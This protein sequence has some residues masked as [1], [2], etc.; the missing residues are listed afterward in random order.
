MCQRL[1][2]E[3]LIPDL[4]LTPTSPQSIRAKRTEDLRL[5]LVLS[6][7]ARDR[8]FQLEFARSGFSFDI[9]FCPGKMGTVDKAKPFVR[10]GRKAADL[11]LWGRAVFERRLPLHFSDERQPGCDL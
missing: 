8:W 10:V 7:A 6:D 4:I 3:V 5:N 1:N 11:F 2:L 9:S